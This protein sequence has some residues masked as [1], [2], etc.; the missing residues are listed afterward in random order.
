M[1]VGPRLPRIRPLRA[2]VGGEDDRAHRRARAGPGGP[3]LDRPAGGAAGGSSSVCQFRGLHPDF[4]RN[5]RETAE[6]TNW[7]TGS[8]VDQEPIDLS[9][10]LTGTGVPHVHPTLAARF[11]LDYADRFAFG[12]ATF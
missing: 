7:G 8:V 11:L 2:R 10:V 3:R 1:P 12:D 9:V 6:L 4:V 5:R